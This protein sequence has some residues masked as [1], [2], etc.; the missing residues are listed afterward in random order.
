MFKKILLQSGLTPSQAE[1]LN[2]LYQNK[3]AKASVIAVKIKRSRAIVYKEL[4]ELENLGM[5]E[6]TDK[7]NQVSIFRANHPSELQ[8]LH[9][10]RQKKLKKD[11]ESLNNYLPDIVSSFN[12]T[13]N[14]PGV[15]Y[16]EGKEGV[17]NA[18]NHI[19]KGF[20]KD[21]EIISFVKVLPEKHEKE[22]KVAFDDFIKKRIKMKIKTRVLAI[23]TPEGK[24]LQKNDEK[25]LRETRL[26]E[27]SKSLLNFNG[28]EIFIYRNEI[29]ALTLKN[30]M[31][32][33]FIVQDENITQL[34]RAFFESEWRL[35][36]SN[37]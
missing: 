12:L 34:F 35:A 9:E 24:K 1:I 20:R 3:E 5:V 10:I 23:K 13:H 17:N 16:Y 29:C 7:P 36:S 26:V 6:R 8:K 32:F 31:H 18:L 25:S 30:N 2:F 28:G 22:V 15:L 37:L 27:T 33:A 21:R 19:I 11:K 4:E 14:K